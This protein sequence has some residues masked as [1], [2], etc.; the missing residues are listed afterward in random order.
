MGQ[1]K[2]V[3][4]QPKNFESRYYRYYNIFFDLLI[5]ELYKNF[6]I[7]ESRYYKYANSKYYSTNLLCQDDALNM[8]ECEMIIENYTTKEIKILSVSDDLTSAILNLQDSNYLNKVL[9]AQFNRNKILSHIKNQNNYHKYSPWIYFPQNHYDYEEYYQYRLQKN[10]LIDKF[11]FRGTSLE[12]RSIIQNFDK[13]LFEGGLP[14]G[15]FDL[16]AKDLLNHKMA[17]SIAG[18]GEFCYRDIECMAMG[19]PLIRFKYHSEM[20]PNLI[21]DYHY[22]SVDRPEET[23]LDSQLN[24]SHAIL[25]QE[26]FLQIKDDAEFLDFIASNARNY[27]NN[28]ICG[29]NGVLH[30]IKLLNLNQWINNE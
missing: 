5:Q 7:L 8:L 16:Y 17:F 19:I 24:A 10:N 15:G 23:I 14:I 27:Y 9:V 29:L 21:P 3:I 30:T 1:T 12:Y 2:L 20:E 6:D 13:S 18:R 22:I 26:K 25:I 28:N 4:H 11:Y